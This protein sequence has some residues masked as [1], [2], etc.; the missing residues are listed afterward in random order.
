MNRARMP[1]P[2]L[3]FLVL[4]CDVARADENASVAA[5]PCAQS[6]AATCYATLATQLVESGKPHD[7]V[8]LLKAG[9]AANPESA[10]LTL[11]LIRAYQRDGNDMWAFR[12]AADFRERHPDD[13]GVA[14][15]IAW[16]Y[17]KQGLLD[18]ARETLAADCWQAPVLAARRNLLLTL[19]EQNAHH[20]HAAEAHLNAAYGAGRAYPEDREAIGRLVA[21]DPGYLAPVSGRLDLSL[22]C[23]GNALAG[24][25]VDPAATGQGIGSSADGSASWLRPADGCAPPRSWMCARSAT[26]P[27]QGATC[28]IC[29]SADGPASSWGGCRTRC[30]PIATRG[31]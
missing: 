11:L 28:R 10:P 25:P 26:P 9:I 27:R 16:L 29:S 3:V 1:L 15:W 5:E 18:E 30:S 4:V 12:T 6:P 23:T 24:S 7:A 14:A 8:T 2:S 17:R 31:C 22:G 19:I 20:E 21:R 13:C